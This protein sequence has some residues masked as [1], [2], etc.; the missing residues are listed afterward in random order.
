MKILIAISI[1]A[2][3]VFNN[4]Y[5]DHEWLR[6]IIIEKCQIVKWIEIQTTKIFLTF[7]EAIV[8]CVIHF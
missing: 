2:S 1:V 7:F 8:S 6:L 4:N 5:N 3:I